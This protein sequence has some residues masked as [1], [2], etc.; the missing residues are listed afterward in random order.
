M[1]AFKLP[2]SKQMNWI[3]VCD[4]L[5]IK[6]TLCNSNMQMRESERE[7]EIARESEREREIARESARARERESARLTDRYTEISRWSP[8]DPQI[9]DIE[10]PQRILD[11][12]SIPAIVIDM[13]VNG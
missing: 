11:L 13:G 10:F 8:T 3:S 1:T 7:R 4:A 6:H 12:W 9:G 5:Q 2:T